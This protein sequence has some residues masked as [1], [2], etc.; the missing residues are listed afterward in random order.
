MTVVVRWF[1]EAG[2]RNDAAA[3]TGAEAGSQPQADGASPDVPTARLSRLFFVV[4]QVALQ[5]L[6]RPRPKLG[7]WLQA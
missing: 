7:P 4:G 6:V 2:L 3:Q 1:A 5:H